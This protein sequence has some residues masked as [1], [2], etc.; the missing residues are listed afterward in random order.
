MSVFT[1]ATILE[2][3]SDF[4]RC[5]YKFMMPVKPASTLELIS[6][7]LPFDLTSSNMLT[8]FPL[9]VAGLLMSLCFLGV[10]S[11]F[12]FTIKK[13]ATCTGK[14]IVRFILM[15]LEFWN[16]L[17]NLF[18]HVGELFPEIAELLGVVLV[19][20]VISHILF[21]FYGVHLLSQ[22]HPDKIVEIWISFAF[23]YTAFMSK[24]VTCFKSDWGMY[25]LTKILNVIFP[26][27]VQ[28]N[29]LKLQAPTP[30]PA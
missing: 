25:V 19:I 10:M 18:N 12:H 6:Q 23:T 8:N 11:V 1:L 17:L 7:N 27:L 29:L 9:V 28:S 15:L 30:K 16:L 4:C 21:L 2:I 5:A 14:I 20:V 3:S 26:E 13:L 22:L 24:V